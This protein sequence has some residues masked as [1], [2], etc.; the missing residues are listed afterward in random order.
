MELI[1]RAVFVGLIGI[2]TAD[3]F[4]SEQ[5]SKQL[6]LLLGLGPA[7]LA[8][9]TRR[10]GTDSDA[11]ARPAPLAPTRLEPTPASG[12]GAALSA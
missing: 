1:S 12:A 9:A 5:F 10:P 6:W 8:M 11:E 3:F 7:L 2:L 4:A